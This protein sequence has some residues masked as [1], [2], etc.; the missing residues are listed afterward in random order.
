MSKTWIWSDPHFSHR[1]ILKYEERPFLDTEHMDNHLIEA[2]NNTVE[3]GDIVFWLGDMF[4]CNSSRIEYI[5]SR[6]QLDKA[7]NILI[8]GNHDGGISDTKF[9][10]LGFSPHKMYW[11]L[12]MMFTHQPMRPENIEW[13]RLHNMG[14]A[15]N[16]HGHTHSLDTGLD[17]TRWQC[18]SV[19][20]TGYKP[21][22]WSDV[23]KRA[24]NGSAWDQWARKTEGKNLYFKE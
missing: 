16:V 24:Q 1:N 9:R 21:I 5:C 19:E 22:L 8:R 15:I 14:R 13:L 18:V 6:L 17:P 2:Y 7:R 3:E 20:K 11:Y 12:G 23:N 4:F 10:R